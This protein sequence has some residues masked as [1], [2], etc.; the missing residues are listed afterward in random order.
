MGKEGMHVL[1]LADGTKFTQPVPATSSTPGLGTAPAPRFRLRCR[2]LRRRQP[3]VATED[4]SQEAQGG[5][6]QWRSWRRCHHRVTTEPAEVV[7]QPVFQEMPMWS[8]QSARLRQWTWENRTLRSK[9]TQPTP[10]YVMDVKDAYLCVP[11][12]SNGSI[13][14]RA[15][16]CLYNDLF[17][18]ARRPKVKATPGKVLTTCLPPTPRI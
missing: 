15:P 18:L 13:T 4:R 5:G 8:F 14:V 7:H 3:K 1:A 17:E 9:P 6:D 16:V 12:Q 2:F 11:Q 10:I